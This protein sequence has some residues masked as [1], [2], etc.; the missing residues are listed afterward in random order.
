MYILSNIGTLY[1]ILY[2]YAWSMLFALSGMFV[3]VYQ[4]KLIS[5]KVVPESITA[6]TP[7]SDHNKYVAILLRSWT[8][9]NS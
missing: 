5:E 3:I 4:I 9:R 6:K 7:F 2:E 1:A 8:K